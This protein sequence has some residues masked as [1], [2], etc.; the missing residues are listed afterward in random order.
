MKYANLALHSY[1]THIFDKIWDAIFNDIINKA[2][3]PDYSLTQIF[4][5]I[6]YTKSCYLNN[7]GQKARDM[8]YANIAL[9]SYI[10]HIID[11]I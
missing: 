4:S 9:H 11:E 2:Y 6:C 7:N 5:F 3:F 8:E 1:V 10:T